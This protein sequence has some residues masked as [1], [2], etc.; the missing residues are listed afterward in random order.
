M[1]LFLIIFYTWTLC[2]ILSYGLSFAYHQRR[3]PT[4]ADEM[5]WL[6]MRF[7]ASTALAGPINLL[8]VLINCGFRHGFKW[9]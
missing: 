3:Y 5:Y 4:I 6:D 8:V 2:G 9:W 7:C 1:L